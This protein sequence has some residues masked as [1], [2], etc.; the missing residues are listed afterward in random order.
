MYKEIILLTMSRKKGGFCT[1]GIDIKTGN[2]VRI[3]SD[4]E[5]IQHAVTHDDMVYEDESMPQ[6]MDII[7]IKCK[8]YFPNYYQPENYV[9]NNSYYWEKTGQASIKELL[10]IHPS[11]K[12]PFIFHDTDRCISGTFLKNINEEDRHSLILILPEDVCIHVQ[13]FPEKKKVT[14]SF[15]YNGNR[16]RYMSIT[17]TEFENTYLQYQKGNYKYNQDCLLVISLGD[18]HTDQMHY[19]IIAKVLNAD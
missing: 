8:K 3:V 12:M 16:Y 18:I 15:N 2:W 5:S 11:E 6:I 17:D 14:L 9:L 4:N 13:E 10:Q 1:T 7:K 19:K